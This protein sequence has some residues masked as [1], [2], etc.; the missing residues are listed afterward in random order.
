MRIDK[1]CD[2]LLML[3]RKIKLSRNKEFIKLKN[4]MNMIVK[5]EQEFYDNIKNL[6]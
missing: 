2:K 6:V 3:Y 5:R 1:Y 4:E